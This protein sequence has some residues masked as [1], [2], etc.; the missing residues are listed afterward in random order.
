MAERGKTRARAD[1]FTAARVD[2]AIRIADTDGVNP[3]LEYMEEAGI[4]RWTALR[5]LCSPLMHRRRERRAN[6]R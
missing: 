4:P 5:V 6:P 3:A 1:G 2:E